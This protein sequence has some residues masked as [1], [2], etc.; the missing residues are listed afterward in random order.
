M[1]QMGLTQ[2]SD[3]TTP[4]GNESNAINIIW[5]DAKVENEENT[6]YLKSL[7]G[8]ANTK[9][10]CYKNIDDAVVFIKRLKFSFESFLSSPIKRRIIPLPRREDSFSEGVFPGAFT[11]SYGRKIQPLV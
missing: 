7:E 6:S 2:A 10:S 8:I 5:I 11:I 4:E 9:I 1:G 3:D